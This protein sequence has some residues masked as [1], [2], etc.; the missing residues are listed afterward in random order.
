MFGRLVTHVAIYLAVCTAVS[1][2]WV[3]FGHGTLDDLGTY[4]S[5]PSEALDRD[6]WPAFLWIGWGTVVAIHM[7]L[8]LGR[9]LR[10]SYWSHQ[11][12]T[13]RRLKATGVP[14]A[15]AMLTAA[16]DAE[17]RGTRTMPS[18][19]RHVVALFTDIA[20]STELNEALGDDRWTSL[21]IDHRALV[22]EVTS[23]H[24]GTEV[25]TQGDGF[26][27]RFDTAQDAVDS[28]CELQ[29]RL[30][31]GREDGSAVPHVR[32]GVHRGDAMQHDDDVLGHT[33]NIAARVMDSGHPDE[34]LVTEPVADAID[35]VALDDRG[36]VALRGVSQ[37]RHVLAVRWE[38]DG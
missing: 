13:A 21:L 20:G 7:A 31:A 25:N 11:M 17:R 14:A 37:P 19:R 27:V 6:F 1:L 12:R 8:V 35:G 29:H 5:S 28:A 4:A 32:I 24:G 33:V 3:M 2:V 9:L 23:Q 15:E 30:R 18:G 10:P 34:I 36:L 26:F 38:A 22:R 16:S